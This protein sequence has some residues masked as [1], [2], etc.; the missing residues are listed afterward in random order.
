MP[1][2]AEMLEPSDTHSLA[3]A[4]ETTATPR[5]ERC[6]KQYFL[7]KFAKNSSERQNFVK[8]YTEIE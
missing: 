8:K 2:A 3:G 7:Q 4:Q 6:Q 5:A 1:A